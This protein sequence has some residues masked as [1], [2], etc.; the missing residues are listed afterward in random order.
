[1]VLLRFGFV[2]L[3]L[4]ALWLYAI[5]DVIATDESLMRNLPKPVW[6]LI[7]I[8]LPDIGSL[9][10]LLLGRPL[11]AGWRP[12]DTTRRAPKRAIGPEDRD[13]FPTSYRPP[14]PPRAVESR[15]T[16]LADWEERLRRREEELR[17]REEGD[18]PKPET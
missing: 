6:L 12:G 7:V 5:F 14:A 8:F 4:L 3:V 16:E 13:D 1:M 2:P 10:W 17:R 15:E 9:A 11:Y 18:D